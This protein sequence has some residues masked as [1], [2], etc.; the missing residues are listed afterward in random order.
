VR[1]EQE[2]HEQRDTANPEKAQ[3]IREIKDAFFAF[4]NHVFIRIPLW[5]YCGR[6]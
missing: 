6:A 1:K 5:R 2:D 3:G 4:V